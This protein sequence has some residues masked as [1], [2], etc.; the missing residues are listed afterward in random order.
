[1]FIVTKEID[2]ENIS[3]LCRTCL[4]EDGEK[5]VC[6]F[7][8]PAGSSLAAKLRSLSCLEVWQGDGLPEKMCDR[9][10]TRAE[11][12]LLY[13]EQC[14]AADIALR[15]AADKV[16]GLT[17]YSTVAGCKLYQ[18]NQG[19]IP[20]ETYRK[21]LKCVE[22]SAVFVNYEEL[23]AHNRLHVSSVHNTTPVQHM[24]I[25]EPRNTYFN[26]NNLNGNLAADDGNGVSSILR[27]NLMHVTPVDDEEP[28]RA[29][30]AL[31]CSL[32]N[33]TF[34]N[35]T[36]L[37]SHN[38]THSS[39]N[40]DMSSGDNTNIEVSE[41]SNQI[42]QNLSYDR[43]V[44]QTADNSI[45]N[46]SFSRQVVDGSRKLG[47][48]DFSSSEPLVDVQ[49]NAERVGNSSMCGS[50]QCLDAGTIPLP[51]NLVFSG[52]ISE[53][54][55]VNSMPKYKKHKCLLC[56]KSFAQKSKLLTHQLSH[57]GL[58][59]FKCSICEK[60]YTSKSKLNAHVRLHTKTNVH[61]CTICSKAFA[62][63]SYLE[64]HLRTH[65]FGTEKVNPEK[66]GPFE[67][68]VCK[69]KFRF[70]K[71]FKA[72]LRLHTGENLFQCEYC[73]K[74]FSQKY[75]LKVHLESHKDLKPHKCEFCEKSFNQHGNLVE[76]LRIH[77][78]L[79]PYKCD[80]CA[81]SFSQSSHLKNHKA[82]HNTERDHSCRLCGK[83]FKLSSHLK[84]HLDLHSGRKSFKC[85]EC[86]Q[87]FSQAFS[88]KRHLKRHAETH[89]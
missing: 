38:F 8:G 20:N 83:K 13:R 72:H 63:A 82:S 73:D 62:F 55:K 2:S 22:C 78:K 30:C 44:N 50:F 88:L 58:R 6:L 1:M 36:Q 48:I 27:S 9:C 25:V 7:V 64:D 70:L 21:I 15:Q 18:Q 87:M 29:A 61:V 60:A 32:C 5:M 68:N 23:C 81:K 69:K 39:D 4:R 3:K 89:I 31:H 49:E 10:V 34:T 52:K 65:K 33:H 79:K 59:P 14:R 75:N 43:T 84:R 28:S 85:G 16:S 76:H 53:N 80:L 45:Q 17:S 47:N 41:D 11:S 71:N 51:E 66:A 46:L 57:T 26:M 35:R 67:C 40:I 42:A 37:I 56:P 74:R 24:H 19:Y 12:A 54:E 77:K 86:N